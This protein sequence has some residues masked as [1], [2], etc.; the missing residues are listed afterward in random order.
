M[1]PASHAPL[2]RAGEDERA[3][4]GHVLYGGANS[5]F[6]GCKP[7]TT[8]NPDE[9]S[10]MQLF[11]PGIR[12]C[13]AGPEAG[14]GSRGGAAGR[15]ESPERAQR[16]LLRRY[17]PRTEAVRYMMTPAVTGP[18]PWGRPWPSVSRPPRCAAAPGGGRERRADP[19]RGRDYL[20]VSGNDYLGLM[21]AIPPSHAFAAG[22]AQYGA[23]AGACPW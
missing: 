17:C 5:I 22:V 14:S 16:A 21:R 10:D 2:R 12:P 8:P 23:G 19:G 15:G 6:Y 1:M 18:L 4:A 3:D 13:P 7:L 20:N 9:N 11:M